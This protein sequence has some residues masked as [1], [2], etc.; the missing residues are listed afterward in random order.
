M[1]DTKG[2]SGGEE[3][4]LPEPV[5]KSMTQGAQH[6]GVSYFITITKKTNVRGVSVYEATAQICFPDNPVNVAHK[7]W[8]L[9]TCGFRYFYENPYNDCKDYCIGLIDGTHDAMK[10]NTAP[11][12]VSMSPR[13]EAT[14]EQ[15]V[16]MREQITK[17][18]KE[19]TCPGLAAL[20]K[21]ST[22]V[23]QNWLQ[24]G[25]ISAQ[26]ASDLCKLPD[27]MEAGFTRELLRPDVTYWYT[28]AREAQAKTE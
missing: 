14:P 23:V 20:N 17:L 25:R 1:S 13:T 7:E 15:I 21:S 19:F 4:L 24:R 22:A 27:I 5:I 9:I 11:K 18:V 3:M 28:D 2:G 16:Q 8:P 26:A 6:A 12:I 10:N